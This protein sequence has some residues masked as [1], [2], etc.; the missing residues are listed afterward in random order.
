MVHG[1]GD[2]DADDSDDDG[3]GDDSDDDGDGDDSDDDSDGDG[4]GDG[5]DSDDDDDDDDDDSDDDDDDADADVDVDVDDESADRFFTQPGPGRIWGVLRRSLRP[6]LCR[7]PKNN[8]KTKSPF[9]AQRWHVCMGV[10][11]QLHGGFMD[12]LSSMMGGQQLLLLKICAFANTCIWM[13]VKK[14]LRN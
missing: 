3:D 9:G 4:D 12:S 6:D 2:A 7:A 5:D 13:P 11:S 14:N 1:D 10:A 8:P